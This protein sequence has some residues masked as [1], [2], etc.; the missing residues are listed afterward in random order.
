[1]ESQKYYIILKSFF[2]TMGSQKV[3]YYIKKF[4]LT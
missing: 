3:L 4:I 1:M 2:E